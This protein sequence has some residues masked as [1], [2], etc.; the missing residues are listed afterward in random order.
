MYSYKKDEYSVVNKYRLRHD[1]E[2]NTNGLIVSKIR[3]KFQQHNI[4]VLKVLLAL[5]NY[6]IKVIIRIVTTLNCSKYIPCRCCNVQC[7]LW[8]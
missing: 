2:K 6:V 1:V 8:N 3:P 5:T 4:K 7:W